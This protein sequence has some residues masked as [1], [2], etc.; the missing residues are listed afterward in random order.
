M[1]AY[2]ALKDLLGDQL[3]KK[4]LHGYMDR[5]H[6]KHPIPWDFFNAFN[7]ISGKNLN[8][9]WSSWF[10]SHGYDDLDVGSVIKNKEGYAVTV[11]NIGGFV[12]PFDMKINYSD[13]SKEDIHETPVVWQKDE[14]QFVVNIK[15]KKKISSLTIDNGIWMDANEKDNVWKAGDR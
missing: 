6:G 13:G 14:K 5:W 4:C 11:K 15:T 7:D 3:F 12:I 8:W 2:L 10:F 1:W 9:F